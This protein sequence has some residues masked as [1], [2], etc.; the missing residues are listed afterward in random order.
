M[1]PQLFYYLC[2]SFLY[3]GIVSA[4]TIKVGVVEYPPHINFAQGIAHDKAYQY[5]DNVLKGI[6][7]EVEFSTLGYEQGQAALARGEVDLL[8]PLDVSRSKLR[9]LSKPL[10][11]SVPGLCFKKQDYIP[12]LSALRRLKGL[13]VGVSAGTRVLP[14]LIESGARIDILH[15]GESLNRGIEHLLSGRYKAFYHPNPMQVYHHSNPLS[16]KLAC[17]KF[18]GHPSGVYIAV[19]RN[20]GEQQFTL[21]DKAFS[22]AMADKSYEEIFREKKYINEGSSLVSP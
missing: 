22:H 15:S 20:M 17:T 12:I 3:S 8:F 10:F 2:L 7:A 18:Y 14:V 13:S 21:I 11:R 6:Y 16:K 9:H 19:E 4:E 1:R 5:V